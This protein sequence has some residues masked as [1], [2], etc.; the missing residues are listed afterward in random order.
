MQD[1]S[2]SLQTRVTTLSTRVAERFEQFRAEQSNNV[3]LLTRLTAHLGIIALVLIGLLLSGIQLRAARQPRN[4]D[5]PQVQ[6]DL[7]DVNLGQT[8]VPS[9]LTLSAVPFTIQPKKE[10]RDV[11]TYSVKPGDNVSIIAARFGVTP[12]SVIWANGKLEENP[13]ALTVGQTLNIPPVSGVLHQVA[14]GETVQTIAARFKAQPNDILNDPFNQSIHD[15]KSSPPVLA[16]GAFIMVPGGSKP[17]VIRQVQY[18]KTTPQGALKGTANFQWPTA[19]CIS[20]YF[21]ARHPGL[22]LANSQGTAVVSAD[23]GF[24]DFVGWDNSGYGNMILV[25]HGNNAL[26]RYAHLSAFAVQAGQ[27]VQKGQLIGRIGSTGRSTGPHLHFEI[28]VNGVHRNPVG[29]LQGRTPGRC[30]R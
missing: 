15:F 5:Q 25:N 16:I 26:T 2:S 14:K 30:Y 3:P 1:P 27:S 17:I 4:Y 8:G 20:Q 28:I 12:D 7:P 6:S 29:I 18:S 9:D 23:A 11:T 19:A 13:D 22:D 24:V 10:R 21:W